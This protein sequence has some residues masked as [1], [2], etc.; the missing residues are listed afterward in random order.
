MKQDTAITTKLI[1][2][3]TGPLILRFVF[4]D[5]AKQSPPFLPH[6][7]YTEEM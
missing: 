3:R 2:L 6:I 7:Y 5:G 4:F 1:A